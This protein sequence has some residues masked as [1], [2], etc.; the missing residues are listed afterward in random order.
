M[1]Y[2][3]GALATFAVIHLLAAASPG[4]N[5]FLVSST[6]SAV[7]RRSGGLV[8]AGILLAVLTWSS[9]TALGLSAVIS[10]SPMLYA[11]IQYVGAIYLIWLGI[12]LIWTSFKK[13][14]C[15]S[16]SVSV[17]VES[18]WIFVL[19]GY[20][21]NMTNPKTIAYYTSLF[22]VLIPPGSPAWLYFAAVCV[23][24]SVSSIWWLSVVFL[25][26]SSWARRV[27][28]KSR[29]KLDFLMGSALVVLGAKLA[30][31]R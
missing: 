15:A 29:R 28:F 30:I 18:D 12:K 26:S 11:S 3:L 19:R 7:S 23:A 31:D 21:V 10:K 22:A 5:L 27:L 14:A 13:Q 8:V 20:V 6:S 16:D 17:Q 9:V 24:V 1:S 2:Y 25:F 4:P